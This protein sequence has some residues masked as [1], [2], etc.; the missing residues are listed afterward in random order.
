MGWLAKQK[1]GQ[2]VGP[3]DKTS[4]TV[5]LVSENQRHGAA[6]IERARSAAPAPRTRSTS[7]H[8]NCKRLTD[9]A[10]GIMDFLPRSGWTAPTKRSGGNP[11]RPSGR[12]ERRGRGAALREDRRP[13]AATNK[14]LVITSPRDRLLDKH[15]FRSLGKL[16]VGNLDRI[17]D[18]DNV[19][20]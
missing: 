5:R 7:S 16:H 19:G 8:A 1:P 12:A 9:F 3:I 13:M 17:A 18:I 15:R 14:C 4:R 6:G 2:F 10:S 20:N 11:R